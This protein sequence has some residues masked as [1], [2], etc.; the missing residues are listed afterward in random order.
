MPGR[1][2]MWLSSWPATTLMS[3]DDPRTPAESSIHLLDRAKAGDRGA[4][5]ALMAR[6]LPRL[7]RWASGRLP[8][9]ARDMADT[10]DLV[11]ETLLQ[12][13]KGIERFEPRGEGA[14]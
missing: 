11:Q 1:A 9:W 3:S 6:H 12:T 13:F 10:Q 4:L 8:R 5:D 14:F 7:R 2:E